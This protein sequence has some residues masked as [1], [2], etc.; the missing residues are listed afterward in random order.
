MDIPNASP[1][2][3]SFLEVLGEATAERGAQM[4]EELLQLGIAIGSDGELSS[5]LELIVTQASRFTGSEAATLFLREG[6]YLR[7]AVVQ[8]EVTARQ[9]GERDMQHGLELERLPLDVPSLAGHVANSGE[10][11]NVPEAYDIPRDAPYAFN[12]RV[13]LATGYR[14][15]PVLPVPLRDATRRVQAVLQRMK[16]ASPDGRAIPINPPLQN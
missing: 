4:L 5:V 3:G 15:H 2:V 1:G 14:T 7:F 10:I 11:L 13:D 16:T 9:L 6:A 8:N 12:W